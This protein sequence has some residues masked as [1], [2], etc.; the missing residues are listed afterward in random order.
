MFLAF[1]NGLAVT[2][3]G[4][5]IL[6][7]GDGTA[8][9]LAADDFRIVNGGQTTGSIFRAWRKDDVDASRLQVPV[10][11]VEIL[12]DGDIEEIAP[13][14]SQSANN[15]NK[16]D[17]AD[18][19]S[20]HPFHRRMQELSGRSGRPRRAVCNVSHAGS[21]NVRAVATKASCAGV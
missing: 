8:D 20:N 7:H 18:F 17:M 9:L 3:T 21:R 13:R 11:I 12:D 14:I 1:D 19:S 6:D 15:Q 16:V 4:L 2:A 10:K 5:R